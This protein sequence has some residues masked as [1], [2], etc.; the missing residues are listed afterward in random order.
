MARFPEMNW[1]A[2]N[3][4]E[5]FAIFKQRMQLSILDHGI[6]EDTEKE[7]I[8]IKIKIAVGSTGLKKINC[9]GV[10]ETDQKDPT[11]L[12]KIFEDQL[13][14]RVNF[15]VHRL[16][17]MKYTQGVTES[18]DDFVG[19]CREKGRDCDFSPEELAERVIELTIAS[20]TNEAFQKELLDKPKGHP[21]EEVLA[22]GRKYEAMAA[23]K[24]CLQQLGTTIGSISSKIIKCGQCGLNHQQRQCPAYNDVC[25]KCNK[26]GHWAN[27]CRNKTPRN[28]GRERQ[29]EQ[30]SD[31][32]RQQSRRRYGSRRSYSQR[33]IHEMSEE[34]QD[35][36]SGQ[37]N[38]D[39]QSDDLMFYCVSVSGMCFDSVTGNREEAFTVVD[40]ICPEKTG[41]HRIKLKVDTGASGNT[42]P[43]RTIKQIYAEGWTDIVQQ[44]T[45]KLTAYNGS[46]IPC[47]GEVD[48]VCRYRDCAWTTQ[49]FY[50]VDVPGPAVIGL[51]T[52][53]ALKVVTIHA[54]YDPP[55][56]QASKT[57]PRITSI[58][59]LLSKYPEQ[60]DSIGSF[61]GEARLHLKEDANP[62]IDAPRK[63]SVNL[64]EKLRE[65]LQMMEDQGVIRKITHHTD[66]CSSLTTTVKSN[67]ALRVC[68]DPKRLNGNLKRC[69]HKI[70]TLEELNPAFSKAKFFSKLDAKAGYWSVHLAKESQELT[71]F[72]TPFGRYCFQRLPFGLATSQDIFQQE[73]DRITNQVPGCIG[74][75][76]DVAVVG[77]TEEEHD[78]NLLQLM[79]TAKKEG[80]VF[81]SSKCTIKTDKIT[82]FGSIY[83][84]AGTTPDPMKV[85]DIHKMPTPQ[86]KED[87]QRFLGMMQYLAPYI[88]KFSEKAEPLRGL[89]KKDVPFLWMEDHQNAFNMLKSTISAEACLRYYD[90]Q[91]ATVL[92][93]DA[94]M[95]GLGACLSQE[96]KPIAF[97]SKSL[98]AAQ[99][100]YSNIERETLA[101]VF[102]VSRFHTYLFGKKFTILTDHKP[103]EMIWRKP[104]T[105]APPRLQRLLVKLQGY[106][107]EVKYKPG[108]D[109]V[110]ADALS[111]LPNPDKRE[112][113]PL[114]VGIDGVSM[115]HTE[116]GYQMDMVHFGCNK[117]EELRRSTAQDPVLRM[118][119]ETIKNGWPETINEVPTDVRTY[120]ACRDELGISDGIIF[121]GKQVVIPADQRANILEQLHRGHMGIERTRKL[122]RTSVYWPGVNKDIECMTKKCNTC[123]EQLPKQQKEP[124]IIHEVP[125]TPW[126]KLATDIFS[127]H[128]IEYLVIVDYHSKY[129]IVKKLNGLKSSTIAKIFAEAFS[130]FGRPREIVSDNATQFTGEP[131]QKLME[132]WGI[133]HTTSSPRYPRANGMAERFVQTIKTT[134]KKCI[135]TNGDVDMA[136][137][138]MRATPIASNIP[139]PAEIMFGR[140]VGTLLPS[141]S[142]NTTPQDTHDNLLQKGEKMK[143][144]HDKTAGPE[145]QPLRVGQKVRVLD[146]EKK[147]WNPATIYKVCD[148]PRSYEI[149]TPNGGILR[150]NRSHL[151]EMP[152]QNSNTDTA[153][154]PTNVAPR[155]IRFEDE[156]PIQKVNDTN[157]MTEPPGQNNTTTRSGRVSRKPA[158]F[159]DQD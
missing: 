115:D 58:Q 156:E 2:K 128:G 157:Q 62:S 43:L 49:K 101:L 131:F 17:L 42:L 44:T 66:W 141:H 94:S 57:Q 37:A 126:T 108:K 146:P 21:V 40:I 8:A 138:H 121:K 102:G 36:E 139:S 72:R 63:C 83:T 68:L 39:Q 109:M 5:E 19:R 33:Q 64:K 90:P 120:W 134:I 4:R 85:E 12:W 1:E 118:L 86:D 23:N 92:E 136:M 70:P 79:D 7:K 30:P 93:V 46:T 135:A 114:D 125:S 137:L 78:R 123:Q 89:L 110:V 107:I 45:A 147:T 99:A 124:L 97:A 77:K 9:S 159:R 10:S 24:H 25:K 96:D 82:F 41:Q 98:S 91:K 87:L 61:K 29:N 149:N 155:Q 112:D 28:R 6:K 31:H 11:K 48:L 20:T 84:A 18:I 13:K 76:D 142:P 105:S 32:R 158:R 104:L 73:M 150:R 50:V 145:L 74:I 59:D 51:P 151:R 133:R 60:F 144:I 26:R 52:C 148:E 111:R 122:S 95:K 153:M 3:I 71:T 15:R 130:L 38:E 154:K 27:M 35:P 16:E 53:D 47:L 152:Y 88:P 67:G 103:L 54:I 80:L 22:E 117:Q 14:I 132:D 143:E 34:D 56:L 75:A 81:N 113:I 119:A 100:N 129:P 69:P 116:D 140:P 127:L 65:E 55:I 106:D